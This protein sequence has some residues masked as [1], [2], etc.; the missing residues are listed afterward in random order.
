MGLRHASISGWLFGQLISSIDLAL[1]RIY[2]ITEFESAD[3]GLLRIAIGRANRDLLLSDGTRIRRG[4]SVVDLH[5]WNEHLPC[6]SAK[7]GDLRWAARV[8][9]QVLSSLDRLTLHLRTNPDLD[10]VQAL[11]M[12][13][14]MTHRHPERPLAL[15]LVIGLEATAMS[16]ESRLLDSLDSVWVWLLTWAYNPRAL[17]GRCFART[18]QEFW[19]SRSHFLILYGGGAPRDRQVAKSGSP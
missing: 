6:F 3:D 2:G 19:I 7:I 8:R 9:R 17:T 4:D 14:A 5:I 11:R 1:R 16:R 15:L 13:P 10:R 18:R 12:A